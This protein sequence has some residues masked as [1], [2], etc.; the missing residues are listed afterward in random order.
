MQ[1]FKC[2]LRQYFYKS[3]IL[4]KRF[5]KIITYLINV[6]V[7]TNMNRLFITFFLNVS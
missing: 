6:D 2:F 7:S 1:L 5:A 3:I 4:P